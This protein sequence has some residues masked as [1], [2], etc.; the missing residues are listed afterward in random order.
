ML[1][2]LIHSKIMN[3][4]DFAGKYRKEF[5][6]L[7]TTT[8]I[9]PDYSEVS[10]MIENIIEEYNTESFLLRDYEKIFKLKREF[11]KIHP[12]KDGNGRTGRVLMNLLLLQKGYPYITIYPEDRVKYFESLE[13][14]TFTEFASSQLLKTYEFIERY[15][16]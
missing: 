7:S 2:K 9:P 14:N 13:N 8:Y 5:V 16:N 11:E 3:G 12:F 6:A 4:Y 1:I 10:D 15:N